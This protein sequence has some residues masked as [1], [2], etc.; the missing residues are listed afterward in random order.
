MLLHDIEYV[1]R[2][3]KKISPVPQVES[4]KVLGFERGAGHG[5]RAPREAEMQKLAYALMGVGALA[6][7]IWGV[8]DF[9]T[10]ATVD[11]LIRIAVAAVGLG[12][13]LLI[14]VVIRDRVRASR[15]DKFKGVQ[16]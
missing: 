4:G 7:I 3:G 6:L 14:G 1:N 12:V 9:M 10:D 15:N 16:R 5:A 2:S 13:L 11:P 8:K